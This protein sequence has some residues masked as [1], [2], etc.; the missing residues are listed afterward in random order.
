MVT[1]KL[2]MTESEMVEVWHVILEMIFVLIARIIFQIQY[3][4][5]NFLFF[6]IFSPQKLNPSQ[7]EYFT[8]FQMQII[9]NIHF[10]F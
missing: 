4:F 9:F 5:E 3:F 10:D 8:S 1:L 7:L 6:S 2:G